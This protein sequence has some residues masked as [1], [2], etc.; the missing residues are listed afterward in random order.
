[1]TAKVDKTPT[2]KD[3]E[4]LEREH[5]LKCTAL[6]DDGSGFFVNMI[7]PPQVPIRLTAAKI[8]TLAKL[9]RPK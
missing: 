4:A 6:V 5:F 2:H 7:G 1:M 9:R 8:R 3:L